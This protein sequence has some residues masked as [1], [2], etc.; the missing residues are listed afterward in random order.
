M[1]FSNA[2]EGNAAN[3]KR[4][5]RLLLGR[6]M[7]PAHGESVAAHDKVPRYLRTGIPRV[8]AQRIQQPRA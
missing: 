6:A 7:R 4:L 5:I 3:E 2:V 8:H 1:T